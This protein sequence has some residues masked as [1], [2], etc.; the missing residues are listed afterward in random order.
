MHR[1]VSIESL[2]NR[3]LL[4]AALPIKIID[5][6]PVA[7]INWR[8][9]QVEMLAGRWVVKLDGYSGY[10]LDQEAHARQVIS[11]TNRSFSLMNHLG[12]DGLFLVSGPQ[13][14][15]VADVVSS[16]SSIPGFRSIEPDF[17]YELLLTPNDSSFG[18]MWGLHNIGQSGGTVD[19]DIDAPEAWDSFTGS[20]SAVVGMID[21]G[22]DY[23]HPDLNDNIWINTLEIAGNG[24]DDDLNGF[25]DDVR[26]W[27]WWSFDNN[28]ADESGHGSHTA[29]TV[30]AEGNNGTS[31]VGVNWDVSLMALKIGGAGPAVSGAA[32]VA[33]MNYVLA[34]KTRATSPVNV[35]VTNHSWGG[36][37][38]DG[39]MSAAISAHGANGILTVCAAGNFG[40]NNDSSPFYP[41]NYSQQNNISVGNLTRFNTRNSGSNFGATTV[42]QVAPGT[43]ILSTVPGGSTAFFT[44][45][46]MAAPHVAGVA[47]LLFAAEPGATYQQVR[48]AIFQGVDPVASLAGFCVTGGRLNAASALNN[49]VN[50]PAAPA[51]PVLSPGSDTGV[52]DSDNITRDN[53][54]TFTGS[55]DLG[56]TIRIY[57]D[58]VQV[59]SGPVD[60]S[61]N[62][63]V[64][65][66]PL[67]DGVRL[68]TARAV[69]GTLVSPPSSSLSITIDTVAPTANSPIFG[70]FQVPHS[71]G[72]L[73]TENVGASVSNADLEVSNLTNPA[74]LP[75]SSTYSGVLNSVTMTFPG[76]NVLPDANYRLTVKSSGPGGGI[77]DVAGNSMSADFVYD[78]FFLMGDAN[79][80]GRVNLLDFNIVA[81]NFG[82][83]F[84]EWGEGDFDYNFVVNLADFNLMASRFG[85]SLFATD[86]GASMFGSDPIGRSATKSVASDLHDDVLA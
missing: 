14:M 84:V 34:M 22:I 20:A 9:E 49:L 42:D 73:F 61:G 11:Q 67:A 25:I 44:G 5:G 57:S 72:F 33:A 29:G 32:A 75:V 43:D 13:T 27:D 82:R 4:A 50:I 31:V 64:T 66:S 7:T 79:R 65:T 37:G 21:S 18:S 78:F 17:R 60:G 81:A 83:N 46:S 59:G 30:G 45:T 47:A 56:L 74:L 51:A 63:S 71:V 76:M 86:G 10:L 36:G 35:R 53:T 58:G 52:S 16:L 15:P 69:N 39:N 8:G 85:V 6:V 54:P 77:Q 3:V 40:T 70:Y 55:A 80:D 62:W 38:F 2:E 41:A 28:P 68:I 19:A 24:V 23:N 48:D 1:R 26:G 12:A